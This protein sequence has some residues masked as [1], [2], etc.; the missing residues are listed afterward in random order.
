M[1]RATYVAVA[2]IGLACLLLGGLACAIEGGRDIGAGLRGLASIR[3]AAI[4]AAVS[5]TESNYGPGEKL[6][7]LANPAMSET[8]GLAASRRADDLFWAVNDSGSAPR[9]FAIGA[10]GRDRGFARVVEGAFE[11]LGG[12]V[13][14][15]VES[16]GEEP[17]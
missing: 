16:V 3:G 4:G 13:D 6:G 5:L 12:G 2:V 17:S 10:D 11:P 9:L 1:T 7:S 8:S 14:R 15:A